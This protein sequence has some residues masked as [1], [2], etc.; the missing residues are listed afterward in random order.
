MQ[1]VLGGVLE[2]S[3][4]GDFLMAATLVSRLMAGDLA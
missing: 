2:L 1:L 3:Q 4:V